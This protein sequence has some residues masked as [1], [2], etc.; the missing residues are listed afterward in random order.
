MM[1]GACLFT[2]V[3][4]LIAALIWSS[5][6]LVVWTLQGSSPGEML[7]LCLKMIPMIYVG[8]FFFLF[9]IPAAMTGAVMGWMGTRFPRNRTAWYGVAVSL[10]IAALYVFARAWLFDLSGPEGPFSGMDMIA[11]ANAPIPA[12]LLS[13]W[14]HRRLQARS[15]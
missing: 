1:F 4:P 7:G 15:K 6:M 13:W 3:G 12:W 8:S 14:I 5:L 9:F 11:I 10:L 2:F